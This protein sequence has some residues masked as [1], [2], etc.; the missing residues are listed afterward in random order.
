MGGRGGGVGSVDNDE[1]IDDSGGSG[2]S[3]NNDNSLDEERETTRQ[4]N[5]TQQSNRSWEGGKT[6][7]ATV[8]MVMITMTTTTWLW[9]KR[10]HRWRGQQALTFVAGCNNNAAGD[11]NLHIDERQECHNQCHQ[12][13]PCQF[14]TTISCKRRRGRIR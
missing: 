3:N 1:D 12:I 11:N 5:N 13:Q 14:D 2:G 4:P 7:V 8:M 10:C 6:V 9:S